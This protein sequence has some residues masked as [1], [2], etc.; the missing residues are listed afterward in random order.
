MFLICFTDQCGK[1]GCFKSSVVKFFILPSPQACSPGKTVAD[2]KGE[3]SDEGCVPAEAD[4]LMTYSIVPG[5]V[6]ST[7]KLQ[8]VDCDTLVSSLFT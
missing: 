4:F 6:K 1:Y 5:T 3:D 7:F 8:P 2:A